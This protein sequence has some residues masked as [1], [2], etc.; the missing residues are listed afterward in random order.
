M[1]FYTA[2]RNWRNRQRNG[3]AYYRLKDV[4]L[5]VLRCATGAQPHQAYRSHRKVRHLKLV[6]LHYHIITLGCQMNKSDSERVRS[7]LDS[8]GCRWSDS[9]EEA[10]LLGILACS[11]RQKSIDR[12]YNRISRWNGWKNS[13]NLLT[14]ITGCILPADHL[15]FLK[16][17]DLVFP[18]ADIAKLPELVAGYGVVSPLSPLAS[19][20]G[21][22]VQARPGRFGEPIP[23][24]KPDERIME[25]WKLKPAYLSAFEGFIPI[26]NGCD[27]FCSYCAVPY[28]RGREISRP[29]EA[30]LEEFRLLVDRGYRSITLLGQNVNSYGM[31]R[32]RQEISFAE[33]LRRIGE[34][35]DRSPSSCWVYFTSP[36]PGDMNE[37]VIRTMAA[38]RCLARQLHIP[39]QS[40]DDGVL[41]RMNRR[42]GVKEFMDLIAMVRRILPD[43]TLF[44]DIIVG[45]PGETDEQFENTRRVMEQIQFNMAYIA[46]YSPRPG[47]ASAT[48]RDD[49]PQEVKKERLHKLTDTLNRH[50]LE[51]NRKLIG[52]TIKVLVTGRD[53]LAGY[54]A[55]ITE[56]RIV[57]RFP[58]AERGLEGQFVWLR[59]TGAAPLSIEGERV[60]QEAQL[61]EAE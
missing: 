10:Q 38:Y 3:V 2:N 8:M 26:Q 17:F 23:V 49:V 11:V 15:H 31:D 37:E 7:V 12:I 46:A 43:A 21:Q 35:G 41:A 48:W 40:G 30:I 22:A 54:A 9:E 24:K 20:T 47:S 57:V 53:R 28:T 4:S 27:K 25:F 5:R 51:Y 60:H 1:S 6:M 56:G 34:Y 14:F 45:F 50:S 44:T 58:C 61:H 16:L 52:K 33:L 19:M 29:S 59:V 36:H 18:V 39:L 32:G 13:R 42:H 55:G